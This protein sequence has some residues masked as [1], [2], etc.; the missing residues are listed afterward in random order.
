MFSNNCF[1]PWTRS[2]EADNA[3]DVMVWASSKTSADAFAV[4]GACLFVILRDE[5]IP[6]ELY[7]V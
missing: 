1:L 5:I 2:A 3:G 6:Y 7:E 4:T